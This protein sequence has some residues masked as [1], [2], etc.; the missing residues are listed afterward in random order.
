[1]L[2]GGPMYEPLYSR[3]EEF[4][5]REG[6][7]VETVVA[8]THPE[9]NERIEEEFG[10]GEASYDLISTHTKYAPSQKQWLLPLDEYLEGDELETFSARTMELARIDGDLYGVPRNLDIKLLYYRTD[11][12]DGPPSSW[13]G[14][15]ETAA[16]LRSDGLY[17]FVFPG[18]ES[19][20][21]GHFFELHAMAGGKMF[22]DSGAPAPRMNDECGTLGA[23]DA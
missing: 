3:I 6:V 7:G 8:P 23:R 15:L 11:L 16:R 20:L 19:G 13:E 12:M 17:G 1:M 5:E 2:V 18:K 4:E 10:A 22:D 14:L 21:F 9:L